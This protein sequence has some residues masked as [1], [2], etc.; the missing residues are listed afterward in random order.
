MSPKGERQGKTE[1]IVLSMPV[2]MK[3]SIS[4]IMSRLERA[5]KAFISKVCD[6]SLIGIQGEASKIVEE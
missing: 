5:R 4:Q 1:D 2:V 3:K 6:G